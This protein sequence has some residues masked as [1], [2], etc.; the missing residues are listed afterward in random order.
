VQV[1][2]VPED[3][4]TGETVDTLVE[5]A[6]LRVMREPRNDWVHLE[7]TM[8]RHGLDVLGARIVLGADVWLGLVRDLAPR[9]SGA[10]ERSFAPEGVRGR[11]L[12]FDSTVT[13]ARQ[14]HTG[15]VVVTLRAAATT[16]ASCTV[17]TIVDDAT[18][19]RVARAIPE[20][21]RSRSAR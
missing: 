21:A 16:R 18:W 17:A 13:L 6:R 2:R 8:H 20:S 5:G 3:L 10:F 14:P 19:Q 11:G 1:V 15:R 12:D 9:M 4:L 7:I